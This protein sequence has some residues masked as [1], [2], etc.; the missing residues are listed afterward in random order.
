M[1]PVWGPQYMKDVDMVEQVHRMATK[2]IKGME[3]MRCMERLM[4][5]KVE[6]GSTERCKT[7]GHEL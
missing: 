2:M 6:P 4:A 1:C 5:G 3:H 7:K